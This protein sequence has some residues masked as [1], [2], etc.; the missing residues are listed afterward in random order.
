MVHI[1]SQKISSASKLADHHCTCVFFVHHRTP[2][3]RYL[4]AS[5]QLCCK[6]W[7]FLRVISK[8][9]FPLLLQVTANTSIILIVRK[10]IIRIQRHLMYVLFP[11]CIAVSSQDRKHLPFRD[12]RSAP[13]CSRIIRH[14][15]PGFF[16]Q[17]FDR[18]HMPDSSLSGQTSTV[19][20]FIFHL[21]TK[22]RPSLFPEKT[23]RLPVNFLEKPLHIRQVKRLICPHFDSLFLNQ[24]V[25]ESSIPALAMTPWTNPQKHRH[26]TLPAD[27]QKF[28]KVPLPF[29]IPFSF[30]FLMVNPEHICS[31]NLY[32]SSFHFFNFFFP[33][34]ASE[35]GK[36]KLSHY[37]NPRP[38]VPCQVPVRRPQSPFR[39]GRIIIAKRKLF[40]F[41]ILPLL[42]TKCY[43][44]LILS[45]ISH[46][47]RIK[48]RSFC[49]FPEKKIGI[50]FH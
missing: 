11:W 8:F 35:P 7:I 33:E 25:R 15:E 14:T 38:A 50:L 46:F 3:H 36:M 26:F 23:V 48:R 37:R 9:L 27:F 5:A 29:K 18:L 19:S 21:N 47:R 44:L 12:N 17:L 41:H 45:S 31:Q 43:E 42:I 16:C 40:P 30:L 24:P 39:T 4:H 28:P 1:I 22:H 13:S 20:V 6:I 2:V 10:Q 49:F 34:F 32:F